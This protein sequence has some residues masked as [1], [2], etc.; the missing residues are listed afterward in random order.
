MSA[1]KKMVLD[2]SA[3]LA[4]LNEEPGSEMVA[5]ALPHAIMSCVNFSEVI[6][7]LSRI[8]VNDKEA[9][10][11]PHQLIKK[12]IPFDTEQAEIAAL[13]VKDTKSIGLSLGDR[14]CLSLALAQSLPV[15]TADKAWLK[16]K[17][18]VDVRVIR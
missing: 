17:T 6:A 7:V 4:L 3:V 14:A 5:A 1:T 9:V 13:L 2:A 12:C 18:D 15:I 10:A 11:I 16:L 8:G